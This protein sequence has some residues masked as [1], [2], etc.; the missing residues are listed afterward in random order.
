MKI[1]FYP[2][3]DGANDYVP[4]MVKNI[5][6][7][8]GE[9]VSFSPNI[10]E[11]VLKPHKTFCYKKYDVA[12]I[13]WL[14]NNVRGSGVG[15]SFL[16][17]IKFFIYIAFFKLAAKKTVY[18]RHNFYPHDMPEKDARRAK[19]IIDFAENLFDKKVAHSGHL[20]DQGYFYIP[21]PLYNVDDQVSAIDETTEKQ[22][23]LI[24]G[25]VE[26]YKQIHTIIEHWP[27]T[28]KLLIVGSAS[29][30]DYVK[31]LVSKA[32][33]LN[34][35]FDIRF[36]PNQEVDSIMANAKAII[37][38]H[39][40]DE[41]IV[42]GSF[43]HATSYGVS[44]IASNQ[45]F[46]DWL[47][48]DIGFDG[49]ALFNNLEQFEALIKASEVSTKETILYESEV[50]FGAHNVQKKIRYLFKDLDGQLT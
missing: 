40:G 20:I 4:N 33:G 44:A 13:N 12:I 25:R 5:E 45:P 17:V 50:L 48:R 29:D 43:F 37:L 26:R 31:E 34:I 36:V 3:P 23:Y 47:K 16:S 6:A 27:K 8:A 2:E 15:L 9:T 30:D 11:I 14:E 35:E 24:F 49:L 18:V 7:V 1:L 42:S 38:S 19:K 39:G 10:K 46:L 28:E 21:H 41:M 22:Y 32:D